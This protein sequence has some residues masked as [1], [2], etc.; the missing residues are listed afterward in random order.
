M[1]ELDGWVVLNFFTGLLLVLLWVFQ[2][3]SS[4]M[5]TGRTYSAL[6]FTT[7]LLLLAESIGHIGEAYPDRFLILAKIGYFLIFLLDPVD[8]LIALNYVD[9]WM[10]QKDHMGRTVFR[11]EFIAF[12]VINILMILMDQFT[13]LGL[14]YT[15]D[16]MV[17]TR[18]SLFMVRAVFMLIFIVLLVVYV[19]LFKNHIPEQYRDSLI[20]LPAVSLIGAV[21][22][23]FF[24]NLNTTYAGIAI[25]CLV[26]LFYVQSRD[27]NVD[28]L[29]GLLNRRGI[30]LKLDESIKSSVSSGIAFPAIMMDVDHFKEINDKYGHQMGD[31][32]LQETA[33]ALVD[34]FGSKAFIGRFG[35]DEFCVIPADLTTPEDVEL[36]IDRIRE[37]ISRIRSELC[38]D[39]D[40]DISCG[41]LF[42]DPF[43]PVGRKDFQEK[44]DLRMYD[45]KQKHHILDRRKIQV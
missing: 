30:D 42:F 3:S 15:F 9:S 34:V 22:Q 25:G 29:T 41:Y 1:I 39:V 10:D 18:G 7:F 31:K 26:L 5:K 14:I 44:I 8:I 35:G 21:V 28:Y 27:V 12:A 43:R 24:A 37:E 33:Q 11:I 16:G 36:K 2:K 32:A 45:E 40:M 23:I 19:I 13:G 20:L 38:V 17:Y 4:G 6:L